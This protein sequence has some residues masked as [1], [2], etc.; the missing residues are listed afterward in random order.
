MQP[1]QTFRIAIR[2]FDPFFSAIQKQWQSFCTQSGVDLDLEA[3]EL[4]LHPLYETLFEKNGLQNGDWDVGFVNSDWFAEAHHGRCLLDLS[5]HIDADPPEGY[6]DGWTDSLLRM[7]TFEGQVIG[8]PYHDGPQ[9]LI[10]RRDLFESPVEQAA[11]QQHHN[12]PLR[13]PMTWDEFV[14]V[15][16]FF[17]RPKEKLYGTV[18]A[19]YPDGHNT[20]YDFCIQ[21]WT[22]GGELFDAAGRVKLNSAQAIDALGFYRALLNDGA[23]IHPGARD[24]DSVQ[25]GMAF[26]GGEIA[27]MTNWFGFAAMCETIP[28]SRVKHKVAVAEI[29]HAP[30]FPGASLN[31][32]WILGIGSGS[33]HTDVAY[34]FLRHCASAAQDKLLTTQGG[35]GCRKST[36]ADAE[37][38]AAIPYYHMLEPLHQNA[39]ELPRLTHW[40]KLAKVIDQLVLDTIQTETPIDDLVKAA[41]HKVTTLA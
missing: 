39:R 11:F 16:R 10:Y 33:P 21:L 41:Q 8:L 9:C 26:A 13:V 28:E 31:V 38:N 36:W 19:A 27:M 40:A 30:N 2:K 14:E 29:P 22:R 18:F 12:R 7:Q 24:F 32:Y 17:T 25:S 3:V 37:I 1:R 34:R 20:V 23:A 35:I 5:S 15:A 6:P 4:D